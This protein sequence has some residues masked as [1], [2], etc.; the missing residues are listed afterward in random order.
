MTRQVCFDWSSNYYRWSVNLQWVLSV[1]HQFFAFKQLIIQLFLRYSSRFSVVLASIHGYIY[2][3]LRYDE[4][5]QTLYIQRDPYSFIEIGSL[6]PPLP[7][8]HNCTA[9]PEE[10]QSSLT[11]VLQSLLRVDVRKNQTKFK[12]LKNRFCSCF[13]FRLIQKVEC[14]WGTMVQFV[15]LNIVLF[16]KKCKLPSAAENVEKTGDFWPHL[17][18]GRVKMVKI[19]RFM[20]DF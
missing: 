14:L 19:G 18:D 2:V 5:K 6:L 8:T 1:F 15:W 11:G 17:S 10:S 20:V 16:G 7:M 3:S 12:T 4:N 9:F 13:N